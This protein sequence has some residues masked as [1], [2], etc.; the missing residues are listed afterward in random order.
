MKKQKDNMDSV[1]NN[2]AK[3]VAN[4]KT[5]NKPSILQLI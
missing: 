1:N 2:I 4:G 3:D 5:Y